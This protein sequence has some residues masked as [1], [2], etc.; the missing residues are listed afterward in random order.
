[1]T[2]KEAKTE[3]KSINPNLKPLICQDK[4]SK[5]YFTTIVFSKEFCL[6][7]GFKVIK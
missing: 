2:L 3:L 5:K 7:K 4:I 1:M 6:K